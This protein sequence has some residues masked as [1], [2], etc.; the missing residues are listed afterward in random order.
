MYAFLSNANSLSMS[1][2]TFSYSQLPL[3]RLHFR[4]IRLLAGKTTKSWARRTPSFWTFRPVWAGERPQGRGLW[5][6]S[7]ALGHFIFSR[8]SDRGKPRC[9]PSMSEISNPGHGVPPSEWGYAVPRICLFA[10]G[11]PLAGISVSPRFRN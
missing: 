8:C 1:R 5:F 6:V 10:H 11:R 9:R 4:V 3:L 7:C 2:T